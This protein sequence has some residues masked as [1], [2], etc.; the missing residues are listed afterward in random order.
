M[1]LDPSYLAY[2][3]RRP[4]YDHDF[5][6]WS[7]IHQRTQIRWP[8]D[9]AVAV[10][11][12]VSL[13]WF[14]IMPTGAFTAPGH[15]QTAYPDFRHYTARDYGNRVGVWRFLEAFEQAGVT[16]SFATN[17]A[18]AER[19]P[20]LITAIADAGHEIIAHSTDM[21]GTIDGSLDKKVE[22]DMI[23]EALDR[24]E[25]ANGTRP[26]GWL[27]IARSQSMHTADLLRA[28]GVRYCCDWVNDE[29][30]YRFANGL[31]NLPLNHELSDRQIITVQQKSADSWAESM[32]DACDWLAG[33]AE[34][35]RTA[36]L[37][38][39]HLTP[40]I[41][42]LPYRIS[43]LERTLTELAGRGDTWFA[44]GNAIVDAWEVQA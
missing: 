4:G 16:A 32:I 40:Y 24:M 23:H 10:F 37:L 25:A 21:N 15:M 20:E 35:Q 2:P 29:L 43:A 36:R 14:P 34:A 19:Y 26:S 30:P 38:P 12:C 7:N 9:R 11:V 41:M 1:S 6:A 42:G 31:V 39:I 8:G 33:E 17:A 5:Y 27:S 28:A 22:R 13:E 3:R 18:V 44:T